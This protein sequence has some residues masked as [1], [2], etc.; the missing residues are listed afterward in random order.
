MAARHGD[1]H[2][3]VNVMIPSNLSDSQREQLRGFAESANGEN[4]PAERERWRRIV[5]PHPRCVSRLIRLAIRCRRDDAEAALAELL[6]LAPG[7]IEEVDEP[8][9]RERR[10]RVRD[11]RRAG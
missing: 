8:E 10:R 7:G 9:G 5:R 6:E 2:V 3:V 11:L 1:L 4:Y